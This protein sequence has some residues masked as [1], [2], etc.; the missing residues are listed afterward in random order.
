MKKLKTLRKAKGYTQTQVARYLQVGSST[1]CRWEL[2]TTCPDLCQMVKMCLIFG[3]SPSQLL[4]DSEEHCIPVFHPDGNVA[5]YAPL[6][7]ELVRNNC[8]F[9]VVV[10]ADISARVLKGDICYFSFDRHTDGDSIVF[11]IGDDNMSGVCP[12]EQTDD[13]LQI[14]AVCRFMHSKI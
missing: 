1:V 5:D 10:D 7:A 13:N 11:A 3:C 6:T 14:V 2:G 12:I 4:D 8:C 9:G